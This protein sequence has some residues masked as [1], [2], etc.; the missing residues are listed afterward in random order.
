MNFLAFVPEGSSRLGRDNARAMKSTAPALTIASCAGRFPTVAAGHRVPAAAPHASTSSAWYFSTMWQIACGINWNPLDLTAAIMDSGL[1]SNSRIKSMHWVTT[2]TLFASFF[3]TLTAVMTT[4]TCTSMFAPTPVASRVS[5]TIAFVW[6]RNWLGRDS[7][8][9]GF[10][11]TWHSNVTARLRARYRSDGWYSPLCLGLRAAAAAAKS[12]SGSSS[13][14]RGGLFG[15]MD[16][17]DVAVRSRLAA[18]SGLLAGSLGGL[19]GASAAPYRFALCGADA[20]S[21]N[22]ERAFSPEPL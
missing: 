1:T 12:A 9:G 13:G 2:R 16:R 6:Y 17:G 15:R 14:S 7:R 4:P 5:A 19:V 20:P 3:M 21:L 10:S 18:A 22:C 8:G 11:A